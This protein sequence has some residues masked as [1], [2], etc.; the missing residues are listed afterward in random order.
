[1][2]HATL[3]CAGCLLGLASS[4]S[5]AAGELRGRILAEN[6]AV[7]G[8]T[9]AAVPFQSPFEEA[10]RETRDEESPGPVASVKTR[11][12]GPFVLSVAPPAG[13]NHGPAQV[14]LP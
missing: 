9:V 11:P 12:D 8:A 2:K 10:R 4:S 13:R 14:R 7:P 6:K 3:A 1:M 5:L